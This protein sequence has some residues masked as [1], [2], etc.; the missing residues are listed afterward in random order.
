[1]EDEQIKAAAPSAFQRRS[2]QQQTSWFAVE[3]QPARE[4]LA[5]EHLAR[6]GFRVFSPR[7]RAVRRRRH[8][9]EIVLS[10]VFPGYVFV[11]FSPWRDPW[12]AINSTRGVRGLVGARTGT[13]VP[14]PG[15]VMRDL[16]QRCPGGLMESLVIAPEPG[17]CVRF[18]GTA[19]AGQLATIQSLD[20][21][22]RVRVLLTLLGQSRALDVPIH[23]LAPA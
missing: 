15:S 18:V 13:P 23:S 11:E 1:M 4:G 12:R 9:D 3:T 16:F 2:R 20:G 21:P 8:K 5:A 14:V 7:F 22:A 17:Q 19:F 6:Q 10:P